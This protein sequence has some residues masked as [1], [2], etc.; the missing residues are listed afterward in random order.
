MKSLCYVLFFISIFSV[1]YAYEYQAF[2]QN[3]DISIKGIYISFI[4]KIGI[5]L[6]KILILIHS[7]VL[8]KCIWAL[9]LFVKPYLNNLNFP[10]IIKL[11]LM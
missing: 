1:I 4:I 2:T 3:T 6:K 10:L 5:I 7:N 9:N 8:M 11:Q